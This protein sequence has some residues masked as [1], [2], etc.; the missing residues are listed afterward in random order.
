MTVFTLLSGNLMVYP[1]SVGREL[2]YGIP[3]EEG[4]KFMV[5]L[6]EFFTRVTVLLRSEG[7]LNVFQANGED[8]GRFLLVVF[9]YPLHQSSEYTRYMLREW[10]YVI[11]SIAS[12]LYRKS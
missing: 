10:E 8:L 9:P 11:S 7:F 2:V 4:K 3:V 6:G 5:V 1:W 12:L